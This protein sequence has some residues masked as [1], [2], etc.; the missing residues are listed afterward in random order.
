MQQRHKLFLIALLAVTL[1]LPV[2]AHADLLGSPSAPP[3]LTAAQQQLVSQ[4]PGL[5]D[6][7]KRNPWL[8]RSVL[9]ALNRSP[10]D[11]YGGTYDFDGLGSHEIGVLNRNPALLQIWSASPE[12]A[13]D[14]LALIK[15][16]S[17]SGG[18]PTK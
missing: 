14:L 8:L 6:L 9:H 5:A 4:N 13:A 10:R 1:L 12:A 11:A 2:Q 15:A 16:A 7:E 3:A 18:K 17:S